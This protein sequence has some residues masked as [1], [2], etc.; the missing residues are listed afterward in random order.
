MEPVDEGKDVLAIMTTLANFVSLSITPQNL[1][2]GK[3]GNYSVLINSYVQIKNE[4]T[5]IFTLPPQMSVIQ[6]KIPCWADA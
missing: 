3:T 4:D 6:G 1:T 5:L 2:N